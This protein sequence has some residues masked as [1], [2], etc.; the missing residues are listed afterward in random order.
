M[1]NTFSVE[2][3]LST[4][5]SFNRRFWWRNL[6]YIN[7][8]FDHDDLCM[9]WAWSMA[10]EMQFFLVFTVILFIYAKWDQTSFRLDLRGNQ[11]PIHRNN[12]LGIKTFITFTVTTFIIGAVLTV[13]HQF[14]LSFDVLWRTGTVLYI[15][16][17]IR[18][19]PY[20][21]GVACG[22]YLHTNRQTFNVPDVR[23]AK[24]WPS[25]TLNFIFSFLLLR[26]ESAKLFVLPLDVYACA[27]TSQHR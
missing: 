25:I 6:F 12:A 18:I 5:I 23:C 19:P 4:S 15:A 1:C 11:F 3:F 10:C 24:P 9:N 27:C 2:K 17:W 7:N 20:C 8:L 16:P 22:W 14:L 21:V 26:A 13:K